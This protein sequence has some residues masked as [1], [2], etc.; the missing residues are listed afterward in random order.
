MN[1]LGKLNC[2]VNIAHENDVNGAGKQHGNFKLTELVFLTSL[3]NYNIKKHMS[4][5]IIPGPKYNILL[6]YLFNQT[7]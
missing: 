3:D 4:V 1:C 7:N 5:E 6:R 2:K